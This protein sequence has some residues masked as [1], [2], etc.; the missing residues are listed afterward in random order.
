MSVT[1]P[2]QWRQEHL[3]AYLRSG[4]AEGHIKDL[5]DQ[6]GYRFTTHC[7]IR[8]IGRQSGRTMVT[9]LVYGTIGGEIV[10][11][12]SKAGAPVNPGWYYNL[13][14]APTVDV[15]VGT[16]AFRATW[17]DLE[18]LERRS[19]WEFMG[20]VMPNYVNYQKATTRQIP[21]IAILPGERIPVFTLA[22]AGLAD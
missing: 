2:S 18:G 9:P 4:G 16:Q 20:G 17:R 8:H 6:G 13:T 21:V 12:A 19:F 22:D 1:K 14:S 10:V 3:E 7:L 11:V 15:Q 5:T